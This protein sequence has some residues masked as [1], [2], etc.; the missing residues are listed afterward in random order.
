ML[1]STKHEFMKHIY[2]FV[3]ALRHAQGDK[4]IYFR[5]DIGRYFNP[6]SDAVI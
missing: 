5:S 4:E 2:F 3:V 6:T 1:S